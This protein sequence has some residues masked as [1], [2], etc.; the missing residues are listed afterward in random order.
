MS[1]GSLQSSCFSLI[2]LVTFPKHQNSGGFQYVLKRVGIMLDGFSVLFLKKRPHMRCMYLRWVVTAHLG[3]YMSVP[4]FEFSN[5]FNLLRC[6]KRPWFPILR[7]TLLSRDPEISFRQ[8]TR[9]VTAMCSTP[10]SRKIDTPL[11]RVL[12]ASLKPS[13][14]SSRALLSLPCFYM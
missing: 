12:N 8:K 5:S 2:L 4:L 1:L 7:N 6:Y 14:M 3:A 9:M 13:S 10:S 11:S